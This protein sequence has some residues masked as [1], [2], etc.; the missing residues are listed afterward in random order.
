MSTRNYEFELD[1]LQELV[2][3]LRLALSTTAARIDCR[4]DE[5]NRNLHSWQ[6][7]IDSRLGEL[8]YHLENCS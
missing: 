2:K 4:I 3:Q 5:T 6:R 7:D 8:H 1:Q